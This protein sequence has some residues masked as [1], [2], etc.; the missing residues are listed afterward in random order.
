MQ[1]NDRMHRSLS[2]SGFTIAEA[3]V[4]VTLV[5]MMAVLTVPRITQS[6]A[7]NQLNA[8][9]DRLR[10]GL[11]RAILE[12]DSHE[13]FPGDRCSLGLGAEGWQAVPGSTD[14][15]CLRNGEGTLN[16]GTG[17]AS[18]TQ[19]R[20]KFLDALTINSNDSGQQTRVSSGGIG[21]AVLSA[22]G[23]ATKRCLVLESVLGTVRL[24]TYQG[25]LST[26]VGQNDSLNPDN[27]VADASL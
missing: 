27:C 11:E 14:P 15:A 10:I 17:L 5:S 13:R 12:V 22:S 18:T 3:V 8:A 25:V 20:Y 9:T 6:Y 26:T 21:I 4:T 23:T 2:R 7:V 1:L 24:G 19:L 16:D